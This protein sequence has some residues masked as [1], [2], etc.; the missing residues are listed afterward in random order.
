MQRMMALE[1]KR[2]AGTRSTWVLAAGALLLSIVMALLVISFA[3][4]YYLD[5]NG[6]EATL[7]GVDGI[8][9]NRELSHPIE[10]KVTPEL[11]RT[12]F[13]T[14]HEVYDAYG[15][16]IPQDVHLQKIYPVSKV[17]NRVRE[18][19]VDRSTGIPVPI[20]EISPEAAS[21][22]YR[23]RTERLRDVMANEHKDAPDAQRQAVAMNEKVQTPFFYVYGIGNSDTSD[24]LTFCI[25]LMVMIC[26]VLTAPIFSG[27]YQ[28]GADD[29]LRC[30]KHGQQRL[31]VVKL[32]SSILLTIGLF[33]V[34]VLT[35]ILI[36]YT[37]FGWNS[38]Q[39]SLQIVR[40]AVSFAPLTVGE[41]NS[42]TMI[43][44][45]LS[46]LATVSFTLF[47]ST[48][49]NNSVTTLSAAIGACL[50]PT[51]LWMVGSG[52]NLEKWVRFCL[53]SG[54]IG[55]GNSFYYELTEFSF[56]H[57]GKLS[58]WTPRVLVATASIEFFL[59]FFLAIRSYSQHEAS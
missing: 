25:F 12:V 23:Q 2:V 9:A 3:R 39:T 32:L 33:V 41:V 8:R 24:Y 31:A 7:S 44:G 29:I 30:T 38:L 20:S 51:I 48:K 49:F 10:G 59:F 4:Y 46:L 47:L 6:R 5:E 57:L 40:S 50:L 18:V 53:P 37:A 1:L 35:F 36:T 52:S 42:L 27:D 28:S 14:Y 16:D 17:L 21:G 19:Y 56:L 58:V 15:E 54:G 11:I 43:S 34:C 22:F 55:L 45:L 26:T 13:E